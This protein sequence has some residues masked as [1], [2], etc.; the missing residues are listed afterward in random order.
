MRSYIV[1][2]HNCFYLANNPDKHFC[3]WQTDLNKIGLYQLLIVMRKDSLF[4]LM[5]F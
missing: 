3:N 4:R 1:G 5:I 2:G